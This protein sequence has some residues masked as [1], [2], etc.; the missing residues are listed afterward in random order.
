MR[1][2][3]L[4]ARVLWASSYLAVYADEMELWRSVRR[5]RSTSPGSAAMN[6]TIGRALDTV[7]TI[8]ITTPAGTQPD[9]LEAA[10]YAERNGDTWCRIDALQK[11]SYSDFYRDR[12]PQALVLA[13]RAA[14][15]A[16]AVGNRFFLAWHETTVGMAALRCAATTSSPPP[17]CGS[18]F[19]WQRSPRRSHDGGR[20]GNAPAMGRTT[21]G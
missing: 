19:T 20:P 13:E 8:A 12:W 14:E 3:T 18:R 16:R 6:E 9:F 2:T 1:R 15:P 7:A 11:A 4:R 10:A 5:P 21:S 17:P